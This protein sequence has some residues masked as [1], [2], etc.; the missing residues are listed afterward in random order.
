MTNAT[1]LKKADVASMAFRTRG[2][3][4]FT[5]KMSTR[6]HWVLSVAGITVGAAVRSPR[7]KKYGHTKPWYLEIF[8]S[9]FGHGLG[10]AGF[11]FL[12]DAQEAV[13]RELIG[14]IDRIAAALSVRK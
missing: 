7:W 3:D 6:N 2:R 4:A 8:G 1:A 13:E 10:A 14:V 5:W 11:E 12:D 9:R